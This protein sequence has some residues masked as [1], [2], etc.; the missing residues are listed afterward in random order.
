[1]NKAYKI[2]LR[3]YISEC[4]A[5]YLRLQKLLRIDQAPRFHLP[6]ANGGATVSIAVDERCPYTQM[7]T[8]RLDNDEPLLPSYQFSIR[9]YDDAKMAEVTGFQK[10]TRVKARNS[11]PN[12]RMHQPDEKYQQNRFLTECLMACLQ[13]GLSQHLLRTA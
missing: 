11:Y 3:E 12:R 6:I 1:M 4:E 7:L 5:N 9:L 8:L 13:H 10:Q 2:D